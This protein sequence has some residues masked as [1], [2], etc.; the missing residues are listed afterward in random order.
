MSDELKPCPFCGCAVQ[1]ITGFDYVRIYGQHAHSCPFLGDDPIIADAAEWNTR[2][3]PLVI[4]P[5]APELPEEPPF[6]DDDSYMDAYNAAHRMRTA[7]AE[8]IAAAG[9]GLKL[10]P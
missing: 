5:P 6:A 2:A 7:C 9:I 8:A 3:Q 10:K 4:L 1:P